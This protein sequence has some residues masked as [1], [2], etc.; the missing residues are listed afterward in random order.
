MKKIMLKG[1]VLAVVAFP[2]LATNVELLNSGAVETSSYA[3]EVKEN[4]GI[5][6]TTYFAAVDNETTD[7]RNLIVQNVILDDS[8]IKKP[9]IK[10][11]KTG[12][13]L[14]LTP[15]VEKGDLIEFA[16]EYRDF[17]NVDTKSKDVEQAIYT[18]Q[19]SAILAKGSSYCK[20]LNS[21]GKQIEFCLTRQ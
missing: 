14:T 9:L 3:L 1:M 7:L 2:T 17:P 18:L 11:V 16:F 8:D 19:S 13:E 15:K 10:K 6:T 12:F 4:N 20:N 5:V 21:I